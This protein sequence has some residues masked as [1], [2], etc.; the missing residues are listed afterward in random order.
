MLTH[1]VVGNVQIAQYLPLEQ[2]FRE[3]FPIL[4]VVILDPEV[5]EPTQNFQVDDFIQTVTAYIE[6]RERRLE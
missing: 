5:I 4:D 1:R 2:T 3:V 6:N